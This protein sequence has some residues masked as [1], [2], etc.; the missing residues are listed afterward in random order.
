VRQ[1][2]IWFW[3]GNGISWTIIKQPAPRSRQITTPTPHHSSFTGWMF[4]LT[5]KQQ[6]QST[7]HEVHKVEIKVLAMTSGWT[8]CKQ[9][10]M[11]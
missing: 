10:A 1:D 2:T 3:D 5:P 9:S 11:T 4:F 7:E 8:I 6:C